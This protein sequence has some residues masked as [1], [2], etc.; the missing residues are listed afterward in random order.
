VPGAAALGT[1]VRID[2][3][4]RASS[5]AS[6]R[7]VAGGSAGHSRGASGTTRVIGVS[8]WWGG[9]AGGMSAA[10]MG[11]LLSGD[12]QQVPD[13]MSQGEQGSHGYQRS[14]TFRRGRADQVGRGTTDGAPAAIDKGDRDPL[15]AAAGAKRE[16]LEPLS[17]ERMAWISDC[18]LSH[19]PI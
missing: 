19:Q 8:T 16:H 17:V 6:S 3:R 7:R 4:S 9:L 18:Y 1:R 15:R 10:T 2:L 13:E 11:D 12:P 5:W 14:P